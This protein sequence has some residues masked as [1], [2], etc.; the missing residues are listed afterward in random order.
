MPL[1]QR[2]AWALLGATL[3]FAAQASGQSWQL[4]TTLDNDT[5]WR[6]RSPRVIQKSQ[7]RL[8]LDL[9][10]ELTP[11][12]GI[13]GIGRAVWDPVRRI[14][15]S[16]PIVDQKAVERWQVSSELEVELRELYVDWRDRVGG[17][18]LDLRVGKQ[19][20]VWGHSFGLRVLDFV[21][22][23]D[24]REFVLEPF[25]ESRIPTT[26]ARLEVTLPRFSFE[27]IVIPDFES[28]VIPDPTSEFALDQQLPGFL[29]PLFEVPAGGF[30]ADVRGSDT[31]DDWSLD[32][33]GF[34]FRG[35]TVAGGFDL[36]LY[37][38]DRYDSRPAFSRRLRSVN[39]PGLGVLPLNEI[40][41]EHFRVRSLGL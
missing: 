36:A 2:I 32:T 39:V 19:Q 33:L 22:P 31:P 18:R 27:A 10:L 7:S 29:P 38:W 30:L 35:A 24:F 37:Y 28:D 3:S 25:V 17:A 6:T 23:R 20:I 9:E 4:I 15:S 34:G 11:T 14:W 8:W 40:R 13:R 41:A 12:L 26:G 1:A 16:D 5:A 21:D